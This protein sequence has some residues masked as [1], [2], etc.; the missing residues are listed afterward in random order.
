MRKLLSL[1]FCLLLIF[2]LGACKKKSKDKENQNSSSSNSYSSSSA[3]QNQSDNSSELISGSESAIKIENKTSAEQ[4][5]SNG[6]KNGSKVT[7]ESSS[8]SITSNSSTDSDSN[9]NPYFPG[10][11][12]LC[13]NKKAFPKRERFSSFLKT[14][15]FEKNSFHKI[16]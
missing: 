11:Y 13:F 8:S 5:S 14:M 12:W 3:S 4:A 10:L 1:I 7:S 15:T 9:D 2:S 16:I 6:S